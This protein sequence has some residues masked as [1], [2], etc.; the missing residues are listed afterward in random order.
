MA[1]AIKFGKYALIGMASIRAGIDGFN[2]GKWAFSKVFKK[3]D[4]ET[5]S[6]QPGVNSQ[7]E[8]HAA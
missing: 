8:A 6:A 5:A 1:N 4:G 7:Q 3:K 2:G